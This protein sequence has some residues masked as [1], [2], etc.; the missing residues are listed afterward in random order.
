MSTVI[1]KSDLKRIG[2][3][4][5]WKYF[6]SIFNVMDAAKYYRFMTKLLLDEKTQ[7]N[8]AIIKGDKEIPEEEKYHFPMGDLRPMGDIN[9]SRHFLM[10]LCLKNF[11]QYTRNAYDYVSQII[12]E[13]LIC[14]E[15]RIV[16]VD[17]EKINRAK[18]ISMIGNQDL[19]NWLSEI[20]GS[21]QYK[22]INDYSN[23]TKHN[24]DMGLRE[25]VDTAT[26]DISCKI[27]G[28]SKSKEYEAFDGLEKMQELH[29]FVAESL[30]S[31]MEIIKHSINEG[32]V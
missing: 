30:V 21:E 4:D 19:V 15:K 32:Q 24:Y 11:F 27:P 7:E 31:F 17:F 12:N 22:Y 23:Q 25:S 26:L 18:N 5:T 2:K 14:E 13:I 8:I 28:F 1:N 10:G 29:K 3:E 9:V 16:N 20:N 6:T